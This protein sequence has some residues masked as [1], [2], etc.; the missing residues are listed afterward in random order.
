LTESIPSYILFNISQLEDRKDYLRRDE[1]VPTCTVLTRTRIGY[2]PF[3]RWQEDVIG[4]TG[5]ME[6]TEDIPI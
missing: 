3:N 1:N 4:Y 5:E 6:I 2:L